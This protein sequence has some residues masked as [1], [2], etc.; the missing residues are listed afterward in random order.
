MTLDEA[1]DA[2]GAMVMYRPGGYD[3]LKDYGVVCSVN[4]T[5]VFVQYKGDP[6]SKATRPEDLTLVVR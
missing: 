5:Y 4:D 6:G 3:H 1:R 2:I